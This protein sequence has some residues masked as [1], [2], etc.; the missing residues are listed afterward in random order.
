M[1][2]TLLDVCELGFRIW[3]LGLMRIV[4]GF[5]VFYWD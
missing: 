1:F 2:G 5:T 3:A 4:G